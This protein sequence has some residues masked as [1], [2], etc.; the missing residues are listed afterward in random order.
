[1]TITSVTT[2]VFGCH[3]EITVTRDDGSPVSIGLWRGGLPGG[4]HGAY[5]KTTAKLGAHEWTVARWLGAGHNAPEAEW[6]AWQ[7]VETRI[8][9]D[10]HASPDQGVL[11]GWADENVI[12][13][14]RA[15]YESVVTA[16]V[17]ARARKT[18]LS[19]LVRLEEADLEMRRKLVARQ[20]A[21]LESLRA[22]LARQ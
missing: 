13:G 14:M 11:R 9:R 6:W 12:P 3:T 20:E 18:A 7:P 2:K 8:Y 21:F 10:G 15:V 16:E 1:M 22:E 19:Y 4:D 17:A 5:V